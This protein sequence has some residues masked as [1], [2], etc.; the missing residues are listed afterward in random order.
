MPVPWIMKRNEENNVPAKWKKGILR[1]VHK[2]AMSL[3]KEGA[4]SAKQRPS[5]ALAQPNANRFGKQ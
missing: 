5:R 2:Y 4:S 3:R 1:K